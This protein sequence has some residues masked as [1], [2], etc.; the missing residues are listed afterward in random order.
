MR[1]ERTPLPRLAA[2]LRLLGPTIGRY[3]LVVALVGFVVDG[4]VL[5]VLLNLYLLRVGYGPEQI[6]L[7]N[8]AGMLTFAAASLPAGALG[9]RLGS[10]R[11]LAGGIA[12][13]LAGSMLLPLADTLAA[14]LRLPWLVAT[15][16]L[17]YLGLAAFFV[18]TA[19]LLLA[20]VR[21]EQRTQVFSLQTA[22]LS[23]AAF[24]GSLVGGALPPLFAGWLGVGLDD[25][26]PYRYALLVSGLALAAALAVALGL[27]PPGP[28]PAEAP[29]APGAA[30]G[31]RAAAPILGLLGLIALVRFLQVGGVAATTTFF[32]VYLDAALLLPTAQIGA[33]LA[34]GRLLGVPAA[35][36]TGWLTA[37]FGKPAVVIG[38]SLASAASILPL[39]LIPH[40][41]AA[42]LGFVG[43]T[44][45][46]WIRYSASIIY[47]LELAPPPRRATVSG[48]SEMAGGLCYTLITLGGGYVVALAGYQ[49]LFLT[50]AG[51]TALSALVFWAAFRRRE[52][53][54]EG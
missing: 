17:V 34:A 32:N 30:G 23:L 41:S 14:G 6:G 3:L 16:A 22:M 43:L 48:V 9:E 27:R 36:A 51:V 4:G 52:P 35:L 53:Y 18:N 37:R 47:Y 40:W 28:G 19:P 50:G 38:A 33:I 12:L 26:A 39:A 20:T 10:L 15:I 5:A 49:A 54:R 21:P 25:P 8:A 44:G 46:S 1:L 11:V 7:V 2:S 45:L 29:A 24:A 13:M 42:A 31:A